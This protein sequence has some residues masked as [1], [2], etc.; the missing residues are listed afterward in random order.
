MIMNKGQYIL[1][2][3]FAYLLSAHVV[4][5][6]SSA[7]LVSGLWFSESPVSN[8]AAVEVYSVLHNQTDVQ[9]TGIATL[10]VDG[11][12][13]GIQE[14]RVGKGDIQRVSI[15]HTFT[16]GTHMVSMRFTAGSVE[17][18][19]TELAV[20][21]IFVI[22]DTDGDG[23]RNSTDTDDDNDGILDINDSEPLV[24]Q[25]ISKQVVSIAG[26]GKTLL[27][28]VVG[29][30]DGVVGKILPQAATTTEESEPGAVMST[31]QI[32]E[33]ARKQALSVVQ[34][35]E[36]EQRAALEVIIQEEESLPTFENFE[37]EPKKE[38]KKQEHQI[39]AAGASVAGF[40]I[41]K[42]W[43]FYSELVVLMLGALHL[44]WGWF[45]AIFSKVEDEYEEE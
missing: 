36:D 2:F 20:K 32:I 11:V 17:A 4:F 28:K 12:A 14:V 38:S 29:S 10:V 30:T 22:T 24:K 42:S 18:T 35:Y 33:E 21:N 26:V 6:A 45:K 44:L 34:A 39:A 3:A 23:I 37:E 25:V 43:M 19:H 5:A 16:P 13:I 8:F 31:L 7:G 9:M 15:A 27:E 41:G 1:I 40:M